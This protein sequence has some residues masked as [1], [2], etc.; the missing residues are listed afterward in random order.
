MAIV[1]VLFILLLLFITFQDFRYKAVSWILFPIGFITAG[2]ITYVEIPFSDILYN[3]IINSLFIAF[4]MAVILVFSW[5]KF[6]QV[7]NIFSQIFGLG[8][9]LFLVM[10][11]PL[12]S[13]INFVFFYILSL[14]FSLLVYLILKYLKIYNDTK[15]PL[16][17]F[18]SFFLAILFIS[19][20]FIRFSL[21]ND[22]MLFEYL[23]G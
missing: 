10:I 17:G 20:F 18:Q 7:K 3:S 2:I 11:C 9:L 23:L 16:A 8:D 22:Y 19:I 12:F 5:I 1:K 14:A 21:L 6:K 15:I 4:Q 13:P